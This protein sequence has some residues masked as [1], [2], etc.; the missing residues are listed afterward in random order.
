MRKALLSLVIV[1]TLIFSTCAIAETITVYGT[2]VS[3]ESITIVSNV[4]GIVDKINARVGDRIEKDAVLAEIKTTEIIAPIGGQ[5]Q[6]WANASNSISELN[7]KYGAIAYIIP[8]ETYSLIATPEDANGKRIKV[9]SGQKVYLRCNKDGRHSGQ[10]IVTKVDEKEFTVQVDQGNF[11]AKELVDIFTREDYSLASRIGQAKITTSDDV[12]VTGIGYIVRC[13]VASGDIINK[14]DL[15]FETIEGNVPSG[16]INADR[17]LSPCTGTLAS[18]SVTPGEGVESGKVFAEIYP[19][20]M[21]RIKALVPEG[22]LSEIHLQDTVYIT[23]QYQETFSEPISGIVEKISS[24]PEKT[25]MT[26]ASYESYYAAYIIVPNAS[27]LR[28]GMNVTIT[29]QLNDAGTE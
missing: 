4:K 18:L 21:L 8:T 25:E 27:V 16:T 15:L 13:H 22:A 20:D 7:E 3:V 14:G 19:D 26:E 24:I 5:I 2:V 6:V 17:I 23:G 29:N 10:G 28:Y 9:H 12:T 11:V 1:L